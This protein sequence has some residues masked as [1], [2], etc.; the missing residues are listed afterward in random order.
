MSLG[1]T[2]WVLL[3]GDILPHDPHDPSRKNADTHGHES[4]GLLNTGDTGCILI[5]GLKTRGG[6]FLT[7]AQI[8]GKT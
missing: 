4:L 3:D 8:A 2:P 6:N 7:S 5:E 1:H